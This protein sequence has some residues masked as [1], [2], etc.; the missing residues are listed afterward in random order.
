MS[1]VLNQFIYSLPSQTTHAD[2][3][4]LLNYNTLITGRIRRS[5]RRSCQ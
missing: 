4:W 5:Q 3:T 1:S 2:L